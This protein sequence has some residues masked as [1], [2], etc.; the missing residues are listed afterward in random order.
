MQGLNV[1]IDECL[2]RRLAKEISHTYVKTVPDM[3]WSGLTNGKLLEKAQEH[4]D[5]FITSDQNLSFQQNLKK[6]RI[7]VVV[8][9]PARNQIEDLKALVPAL[10][11]ALSKPVDKQLIHIR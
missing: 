11:T 8:L 7:T 2:D 5:V 6:Y 3:G 1:L 4:F 9:C 10:L